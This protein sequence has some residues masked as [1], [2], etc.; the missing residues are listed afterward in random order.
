[1]TR[2]AGMTWWPPD[3]I[4]HLRGVAERFLA[5]REPHC[6]CGHALTGH[7]RRRLVCYSRRLC[8]CVTWTPAG[9]DGC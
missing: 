1:M 2:E 5:M 8:G 3:V 9:S 4:E 7:S 6:T